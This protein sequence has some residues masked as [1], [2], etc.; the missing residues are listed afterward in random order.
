MSPNL[1]NPKEIS[2]TGEKIYNSRYR[3]EYE[4]KYRGRFVAI[5]VTDGSA[6]IGDSASETLAEAKRKNPGGLFHLIRVGH[7]G[8]FEVGIA[9][10]DATAVR[11]PGR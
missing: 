3:E 4:R 6:I 8:A 7:S 1:N 10:R 5:D 11:L 9:Y 2:E